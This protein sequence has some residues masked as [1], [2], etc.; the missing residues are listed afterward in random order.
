MNKQSKYQING[1]KYPAS[2]TLKNRTST[3][4]RSMACTIA[5]RKKCSSEM[6]TMWK[7]FFPD[8]T[9]AYCGEKAT[10]LDHLFPLISD[11]KPTGYGSE[12]ANLVPCCSKCNS[13]KGNFDWEEFMRSSKCEHV[14][15]S[16]TTDPQM[17][18][19]NR[20]NT[21]RS[22]IETMKP[23]KIV[24]D[25]ATMEK[26][27]EILFSF[28]KALSSAENELDTIKTQYHIE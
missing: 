6:E 10:H 1:F 8:K 13:K 9:C 27:D 24:F 15:D 20:I 12:P 19:E 25:K 2:D 3:I 28:D 18:M 7:Q 17:A 14:V 16:K 11:R 26:W 4:C 23:K 22:F 21:I 5:E